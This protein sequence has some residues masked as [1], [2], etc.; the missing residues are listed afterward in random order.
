MQTSRPAAQQVIGDGD[1]EARHRH[2]PEGQAADEEGVIEG[3]GE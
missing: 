3:V 2:H 1:D